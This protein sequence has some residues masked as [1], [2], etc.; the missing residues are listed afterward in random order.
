MTH[1]NS[2]IRKTLLL[3]TLAQFFLQLASAQFNQQWLRTWDDSLHQN[4][5][6]T[7]AITDNS[8]NIVLTGLTFNSSFTLAD[9]QT[10]KYDAQGNLL[11]STKYIPPCPDFFMTAE[12]AVDA[13][14]N[15]YIAIDEPF[16]VCNFTNTILIKYDSNGNLIWD[17]QYFAGVLA[18]TPL[19]DKV[20]L[21]HAGNIYI[22][23]NT[24]TMVIGFGSECTIAKFDNAGN[25]I[26]A[27]TTGLTQPVNLTTIYQN[28]C[29]GVD[30]SQSQKIYSITNIQQDSISHSQDYTTDFAIQKHD[31][32]GTRIFITQLYRSAM[33]DFPNALFIANNEDIFVTGETR[34]STTGTLK[35]KYLTAR[36]DSSGNVLYV[37]EKGDTAWH[38]TGKAIVA[39]N[40]GNAYVAGYTTQFGTGDIELVK[41]SASGNEV[42]SVA[43]NS[44]FNNY[45]EP[46]KMD[47]DANGN[48]LISATS[49]N[50]SNS[51]ALL[52]KYD[53][54]GTLLDSMRYNS[55]NN[56]DDYASAIFDN[57]GNLYLY[58]SSTHPTNLSDYLLIK[59]GTSTTVNEWNTVENGLNVY[60][61]PASLSVIIS[62]ASLKEETAGLK[63]IDMMGREI[64]KSE[65]KG[66]ESE[67][68]VS[69]FKNGIYFV[70]LSSENK[71]ASQKLVIQR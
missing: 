31:T 56:L 48:L 5:L 68:D 65:V 41:Y 36:L 47:F 12:P 50:G 71:I 22:G 67:I 69:E 66:I 58:G 3:T 53:T 70:Q 13:A 46:T 17:T 21:D 28:Y 8:G 15:I 33:K 34:D 37:V 40:M 52:L 20:F 26:T 18:V 64:W 57:T 38:S 35:A 23:T 43:Y 62:H 11:W 4:N 24:D 9:I 45:D 30:I 19:T 60:P 42:W 29:K 63:I 16:S 7:A 6:C 59:Y 49:V 27:M 55:T 51:D 32:S 14:D 54:S 2:L 25:Y 39:D 61:N 1:Q 44:P 10:V